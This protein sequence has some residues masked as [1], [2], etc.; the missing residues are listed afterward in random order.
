MVLI[1]G[2]YEEH[3]KAEVQRLREQREHNKASRSKIGMNRS[4]VDQKK[5]SEDSPK[6]RITKISRP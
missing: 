3:L 5:N 4:L 6:H 2:M 1:K